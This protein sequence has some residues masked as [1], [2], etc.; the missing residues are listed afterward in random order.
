LIC[1][2][3]IGLSPENDGIPSPSRDAVASEPGEPI[4][5]ADADITA[6]CSGDVATTLPDEDGISSMDDGVM[7]AAQEPAGLDHGLEE[8]TAEPPR[9]SEAE[10][11]QQEGRC[12]WLACHWMVL[13]MTR[14][15]VSS[16]DKNE[17][18][19]L[20]KNTHFL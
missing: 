7:P 1:S 17:V 11:L 9:P 19:K 2:D 10:E 14:E 6:S 16:E 15:L 8:M 18:K 12:H 20:E 3:D 4:A 13:L 5:I